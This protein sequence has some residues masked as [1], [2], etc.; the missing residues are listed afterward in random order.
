[1]YRWAFMGRLTMNDISPGLVYAHIIDTNAGR[2]VHTWDE[3][4]AWR[5]EQGVLWIHLDADND[6]AL[7]W[8]SR[9][10]GL[11]P[12][13]Q[14]ALLELGTRPRSMATESGLLAIFR[15]VNCNPGADPEDMVAIRMFLTDRRIIT[16]RRNRVK[17]VQDVHETLTAGNGPNTVG[18][19][20]VAVVDRITERI[21]EVV[22]DIE[23][24]VA[25]LEDTIVSAETAELRP[26][27]AELRRESISLRRYI[28]P[29]RDMLARLT[30][31]RTAWLTDVDR[32]LLREA[33]ERTARYV[34]DIDAARERALIA[35]EELNSRLSEQMNRAMYT[36]SIV[37]AIFLPLG[38]LT[39]LL[40]INVGG[41]PGT[42]NPWAFLIVTLFL[43]VLAIF[44]IA[45]FK[46]LKWL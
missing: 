41:I 42:E 32:T 9:Q 13:I 19:F 36:L 29:Q 37:A 28:A 20:F 35:Q 16:M 43:V 17:A 11:S 18:E 6:N 23:D 26:R 30:H 5:P 38:L 44:L 46:K 45:W 34:E 8:L 2:E 1:M 10:S 15:G 25:E 4:A 7:A 3:V 21:G 24:R 27:L 12:M 33:A 40:G 22:V 31:E 14:E 39:G